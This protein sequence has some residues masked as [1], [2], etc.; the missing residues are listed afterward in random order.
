MVRELAARVHEGPSGEPVR[1]TVDA[2]PVDPQ[3]APGGFD[4]LVPSPRQSP[5]RTPPQVLAL[6]AALKREKPGRTAAQVRRILQV[7]VGVGAVGADDAA[8][9]RAAGADRLA[10][11]P[12]EEQRAFGRFECTRPNEM[13]TG[14]ALHG[15]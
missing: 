13:W 12:E 11:G 1:V 5:P 6:A 8:A 7:A 3:M 10:P 15:R 9:V 2:G 4:A 14:D